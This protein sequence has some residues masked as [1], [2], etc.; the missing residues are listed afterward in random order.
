MQDAN[1]FEV[2]KPSNEMQVSRA[3]HGYVFQLYK[4]NFHNAEIPT[5]SVIYL[6]LKIFSTSNIFNRFLSAFLPTIPWK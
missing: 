6:M 3:M 5:V 1:K 2:G 4:S